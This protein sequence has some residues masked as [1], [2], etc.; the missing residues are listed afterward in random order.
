M[1][2]VLYLAVH[3]SPDHRLNVRDIAQALGI[4]TPF[5][6]KLLQK[7]AREHV[8]SSVKGPGGGYFTSRENLRQNL[9]R[10][11]T[12]IDGTDALQGCIM[13]LPVCSSD[14][15]CPLH[16]QAYALRQGLSYQLEKQTIG[17]LAQQV[18]KSGLKL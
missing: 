12:T 13:G 18:K 4:P 16:L 11:I 10:V 15:P 2:A 3:S 6:S 5:L 1:R 8:I 14:N 9:A 17:E 7:L